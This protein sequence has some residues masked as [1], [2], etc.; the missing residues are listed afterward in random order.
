MIAHFRE[1]VTANHS[2][3]LVVIPQTG[4]SVRQAIDGL[5]LL[6][7]VLDSADIENRVCLVPSLVLIA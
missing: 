7:E 6:W 1:F 5:V 4:V 2:P 3:G